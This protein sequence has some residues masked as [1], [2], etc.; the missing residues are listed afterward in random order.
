[1]NSL[2]I[3][4]N[5]AQKHTSYENWKMCKL[6]HSY[7]VCVSIAYV[8]TSEQPWT[9]FTNIN[10][11]C[12]PIYFIPYIHLLSY[13]CTKKCQLF[14]TPL[15]IAPS[16]VNHRG[17]GAQLCIPTNLLFTDYFM[18]YLTKITINLRPYVCFYRFDIYMYIFITHCD[19]IASL[20]VSS[21]LKRSFSWSL[22]IIS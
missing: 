16:F 10:Q 21:T 20:S 7:R 18:P 22:P 2:S 19:S 14:L 5:N 6:A 8:K 12:S 9:I 3:R 15:W 1:M 11:R 13:F 17:H 4:Q